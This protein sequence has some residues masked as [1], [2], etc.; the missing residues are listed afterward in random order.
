MKRYNWCLV[1]VRT[2]A[3]VRLGRGG[4]MS[5]ELAERAG[6]KA[7]RRFVWPV[8]SETEAELSRYEWQVFEESGAV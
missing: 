5:R 8:G 6:E 4:F 7:W 2:G 1:Q 3:V